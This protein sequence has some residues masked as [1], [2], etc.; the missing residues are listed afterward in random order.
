MKRVVAILAALVIASVILTGVL[1]AHADATPVFSDDWRYAAEFGKNGKFTIEFRPDVSG[2]YDLYAFCGEGSKVSRAVLRGENGIIAAGSG[3]K[4]MFTA[5]LSANQ[6][7]ALEVEG[8]G[9]VVFELMRHMT[10]RSILLP[11][12]V[13][14]MQGGMIVLPRSVMWHA[15]DTDAA[16]AG[17][18]V[19]PDN[20]S[21]MAVKA[22]VYTSDGE[23]VTASS[24]MDGGGCRLYFVPED[25][26]DYRLRVYSPSGGRGRYYVRI[27]ESEESA[28]DSVEIASEDITIR[29]GDMRSLMARTWPLG[30][31]SDL[32][33]ATSDDTIV[34]VTENGVITGVSEGTAQISAYAYGGI[35]AT[36]N[37]TVERVQPEYLAYRGDFLNVRVGDVLK[38]SMQVY[39]A[40]AADDAG[41]VYSTSDSSI[42]AISETGEITALTEGMA[43]ISAEYGSLHTEITVNVDEAPVR[44]RALLISEQN[45]TQDVNTVRYG[46]VNTV[47]N[48]ESLFESA[49]YDG[50]P[51]DISVEVDITADEVYAAIEKAFAGADERDV[52]IIYISCH[53]YY[54][55]GMTI[56]QFVDGS[57]IAACDLER[58]LRRV[59]GTVVV[60][61]DCCD[62]GGLIG[63]YD[64][65]ARMSE[66]I[67]TAFA[68]EDA[69]FTSSKY[70]VLASAGLGQDSYRLGYSTGENDAVTVFAW[71]LCDAMGWDIDDQRRGAL[72][73]DA[74]YDGKITLWE[75]YQYTHRRVM[76]YLSRAGSSYVQDVQ[77]YPEGDLF[78]L[79]ERE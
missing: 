2:S 6:R 1:L 51:C 10:G 8:A 70:K 50:V 73:A 36:I 25:G 69:A 44:Y 26:V 71:A 32:E 78:V 11:A 53:G 79:F 54:E 56:F 66:G 41:I 65:M 47:Y 19:K 39:P 48:L 40:A 5:D 59:P 74:N 38:P 18:Y 49:S 34:A 22:E 29:K 58:A 52:S 68:G 17:V 42:V 77:V 61:A 72:S 35:C 46:A 63:T 43:V 67:V 24:E 33:W 27:M 13:P 23:M 3:E 45:Y 9:N 76:W 14:D 21:R 31:E 12:A 64:D 15:F 60:I 75:A 30:A 57:E 7:Y 37:V 62:S 20:A 28:P 4:L 55:N 16:L